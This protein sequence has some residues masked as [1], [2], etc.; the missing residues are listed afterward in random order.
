MSLFDCLSSSACPFWVCCWGRTGSRKGISKWWS[1]PTTPGWISSRCLSFKLKLGAYTMLCHVFW[2]LI[3][4]GGRWSGGHTQSGWIRKQGLQ[5]T[6]DAH[7]EFSLLCLGLRRICQI[8]MPL[9][10]SWA[11]MSSSSQKA[12]SLGLSSSSAAAGFT[13]LHWFIGNGM[14]LH[15]A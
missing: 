9:L 4:D 15:Y 13:L 3:I 1:S 6:C 8:W 5:A 14:V 10:P 12:A 7:L 11:G 2:W